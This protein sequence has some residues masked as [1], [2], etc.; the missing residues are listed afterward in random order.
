MPNA[1]THILIN[2]GIN[3]FSALLGNK[4]YPA[5]QNTVVTPN[6]PILNFNDQQ[7]FNEIMLV[8]ERT[9]NNPLICDVSK[10]KVIPLVGRF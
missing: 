10:P 8:P 2:T 4:K 9:Y 7:F 3:L 6:K 5:C 1:K